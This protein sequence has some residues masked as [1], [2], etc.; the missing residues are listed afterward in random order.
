[1]VKR[2]FARASLLL[3]AVFLVLGLISGIVLRLATGPH[4]KTDRPGDPFWSTAGGLLSGKSPQGDTASS[5][6]WQ[7]FLSQ[8]EEPAPDAPFRAFGRGG[9]PELGKHGRQRAVGC[10]SQR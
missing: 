8:A 4:L 1:M 2:S 7:A 10:A 5:P 6:L 9:Q 3:V